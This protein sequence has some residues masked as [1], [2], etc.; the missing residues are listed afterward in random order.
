[1]GLFRSAS[2]SSVLD[3]FWDL[4]GKK[5]DPES[6]FTTPSAVFGE[7]TIYSNKYITIDYR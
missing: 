6:L 5:T 1:M 2:L 4:R 7:V 3:M